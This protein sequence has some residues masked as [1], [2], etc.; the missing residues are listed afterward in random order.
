M[1]VP[2]GPDGSPIGRGSV[3]D[4][5]STRRKRTRG[6]RYSSTCAAGIISPGSHYSGVNDYVQFLDGMKN[7]VA[8]EKLPLIRYCQPLS[9][10]GRVE[11]WYHRSAEARYSELCRGGKQAPDSNHASMCIDESPSRNFFLFLLIQDTDLYLCLG[12]FHVVEFEPTGGLVL[13]TRTPQ[14]STEAHRT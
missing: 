14:L 12:R 3:S 6:F 7:K 10:Q 8:V 9:K 2:C 4:F 11:T 1:T 5:S 13:R